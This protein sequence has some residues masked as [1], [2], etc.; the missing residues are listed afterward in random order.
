MSG[1]LEF[2]HPVGNTP[3]SLLRQGLPQRQ[4]GRGQ[5]M[6]DTA[7]AELL[8]HP[9]RSAPEHSLQPCSPQDPPF[10]RTAPCTV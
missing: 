3:C 10:Y 8:S 6:A 1:I 5:A 4:F 2:G 7:S 9:E